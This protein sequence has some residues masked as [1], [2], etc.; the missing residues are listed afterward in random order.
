MGSAVSAL[1]RALAPHAYAYT[2]RISYVHT[3]RLH[4]RMCIIHACMLF[5]MH[6]Q[7][8]QTPA[9]LVSGLLS[10]TPH[11]SQ[12]VSHAHTFKECQQG[13]YGQLTY[14]L[15][16]TNVNC[17]FSLVGCGEN[18]AAGQDL[19][20]FKSR[21]NQTWCCAWCSPSKHMYYVWIYLW[22]YPWYIALL[23]YT[24]HI[25]PA[26][27]RQFTIFSKGQKRKENEHIYPRFV[28]MRSIGQSECSGECV[29]W[30]FI[31][32][33]HVKLNPN[34]FWPIEYSSTV[35]FTIW[36]MKWKL[37]HRTMKDHVRY[38][39]C[40]EFPLLHPLA[41]Y[42]IYTI[43]IFRIRK[44]WLQIRDRRPISHLIWPPL[45]S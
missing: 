38:G 27:C 15:L 23:S 5:G 13:S 4:T 1:N 43:F 21:E 31:F 12:V 37:Y 26:V 29:L 8:E 45:I 17:P 14:A 32:R 40:Y 6:P 22:L 20:T 25:S 34:W 16:R 30:S 41:L 36:P 24:S 10:W 28:S 35:I 7:T 11:I 18:V 3:S 44:I 9:S 33:M 19:V 39:I 2:S 42:R